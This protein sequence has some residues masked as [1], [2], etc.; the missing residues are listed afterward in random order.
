[1][2]KLSNSLGRK[3]DFVLSCERLFGNVD[4]KRVL[5]RGYSITR[6][7]KGKILRQADTVAVGAS[8]MIELAQGALAGTVNQRVGVV[9]KIQGRLL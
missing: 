6:D 1:M 8:I 5:G 9:E 7:H 2:I 4:P 3:K